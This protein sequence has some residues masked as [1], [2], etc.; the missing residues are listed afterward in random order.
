MGIA[1]CLANKEN[2]LY[3]FAI[4]HGILYGVVGF[5]TVSGLFLTVSTNPLFYYF[6]QTRFLGLLRLLARIVVP[7]IYSYVSFRQI[8]YVFIESGNNQKSDSRDSD[9][10]GYII[11]FISLVSSLFFV[12]LSH[13]EWLSH[14]NHL[15]VTISLF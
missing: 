10:P 12:L 6:A 11:S 15:P 3:F 7:M 1:N 5:G 8:V 9:N 13:F 2:W 4:C 14:L